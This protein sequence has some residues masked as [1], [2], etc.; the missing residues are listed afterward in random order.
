MSF[1]NGTR[2]LVLL[3]HAKAEPAGSVPDQLRPLAL[4]GRRQ[5]GLVGNMLAQAGIN[6]DAVLCSSALRTR[7]TWELL[8]NAFDRETTFASIMDAL[9]TATPQDVLDIIVA[10]HPQASTVLVVGHEPVM[11]ALAAHLA[12]PESDSGLVSR[13]R[14]GLPT[15]GFAVLEHEDTWA[16]W[17]QSTAHLR[18]TD[19]AD[20]Q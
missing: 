13:V 14:F 18:A 17:G 16:Q 6:P 8:S 20:V 19:R 9:Y 2:R 3:R 10:E 1:T 15:S 7:Q 11:S 12:H 5:A 4:R